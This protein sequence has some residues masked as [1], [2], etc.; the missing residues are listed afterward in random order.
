M[1]VTL[2]RLSVLPATQG[3]QHWNHTT[4]A[5]PW[6]LP[7]YTQHVPTPPAVPVH[8]NQ[9]AAGHAVICTRGAHASE[10]VAPHKLPE[11]GRQAGSDELNETKLGAVSYLTP[12][13]FTRR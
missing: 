3:P 10:C 4:V 13:Q 6:P 8:V 12:E 7:Y 2:C 9:P 11:L 5:P 1:R